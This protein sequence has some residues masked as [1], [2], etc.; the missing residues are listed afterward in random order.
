MLVWLGGGLC[1]MGALAVP[2]ASVSSELCVYV[3]CV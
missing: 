3:V 2:E 1:S